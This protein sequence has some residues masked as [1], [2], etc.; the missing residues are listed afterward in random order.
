MSKTFKKKIKKSNKTVKKESNKD[1]ILVIGVAVIAIFALIIFVLNPGKNTQQI[2]EVEIKDYNGFIFV[3]KD[4]VWETNLIIEDA[5]KGWKREYTFLFHYTPDEVE[6][7][8]TMKNVRNESVA[9][10]LFLD[11]RKIYITFDPDSPGEVKARILQAGFEVAK[12]MNI[13]FEKDVKSAV[14]KSVDI[15]NAP[16]ITCDDI[17]PFVRVIFLKIGD[18]TEIY[19]EHGCIVVQGKDGVELLMAAERLSFEMLKIL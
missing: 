5:F 15:P 17:G 3:K 7:I 9:P 4:N 18:S 11:A 8:K 10:N 19:N 14:T 1:K 2:E 6:N 13:V 12:V 16:V